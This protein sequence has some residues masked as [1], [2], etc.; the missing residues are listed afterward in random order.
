[1]LS[2][3]FVPMAFFGGSTGVI[4]RQFSITIV[5]A[6]V[7]S[8][9]VALILT[10]ALC[11]TCSSPK[12]GRTTWRGPARLLRLV[13]PLL[14]RGNA[15]LPGRSAACSRGGRYLALYAA[16]LAVLGAALHAPADLLPAEEDRAS[17]SPWC[18]CRWRHPG[19]HQ[20]VLEQVERHFLE[21]E[22]DNVE[23]VFTVQ[24]LQL[25]RRGQNSGMAFVKL[26]DWD[27]R[28]RGSQCQG[29]RR[30][31]DGRVRQIKDAHGVRLRNRRR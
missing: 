12:R 1:V 22:K 2:A 29:H 27:E 14:R 11:A 6:M 31:R 20:K 15:R 8:V 28:R 18:S 13:Q 30:P 10:P 4:Y 3:V 9:L 26:K 21:N 24:R 25:R 17:C 5:S 19:A 16:M 7:L 23:S